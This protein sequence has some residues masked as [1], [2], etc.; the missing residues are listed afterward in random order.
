ME[1]KSVYVES[2]RRRTNKN[3]Y[4]PKKFVIVSSDIEDIEF[5]LDYICQSYDDKGYVRLGDF[6]CQGLLDL[7]DNYDYDDLQEYG[8]DKNFF[9]INNLYIQKTERGLYY[10]ELEAPMKMV[11]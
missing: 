11:L 5:S 2:K 8:W 7:I 6:C 9:D 1:Y 10:V 4:T 3:K